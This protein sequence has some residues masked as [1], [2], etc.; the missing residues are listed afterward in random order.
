MSANS[1]NIEP[2]Q[3]GDNDEVEIDLLQLVN[4]YLSKLVFIIVSFLVGALVAGMITKF[5]ITPKY[6]ASAKVYMVSSSSGSAV[7]LSALNLGTALSSDY[8]VL[9][10]VRPILNQVIVDL[11][12]DYDYLELGE[13]VTISSISDTR[14]IEV[15]VESTNPQEAADIANSLSDISVEWL[16]EIMGSTDTPPNVA[17]YALAPEEP[18]SPSLVR[19]TAIGALLLALLCIA[20]LTVQFLMDDTLKTAEDVEHEFGV[21]PLAIVPEGDIPTLKEVAKE[22]RNS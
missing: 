7:D 20:I 11:D 12:L 14:I 5:L 22:N 16:P 18:S 6:T 15:S 17:E 10:T 3:E 13:M 8:E 4:F 9:M 21:M 2:I 19:N 1:T